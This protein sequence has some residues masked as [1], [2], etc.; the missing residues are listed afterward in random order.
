MKHALSAL[1]LIAS[2]WAAAPVP[3]QA[4]VFFPAPIPPVALPYNDFFVYSLP[5]L[6]YFLG[7]VWHIPSTPGHIQDGIVIATGANGAPVNTNFAGMDNPHQTPSGSGAS[8]YATTQGVSGCS[9]AEPGEV[10][11]AFAGDSNDSWDIQLSA[12]TSYLNGDD[13]VV[14]F[15]H[16]EENSGGASEQELLIWAHVIVEDVDG[17]GGTLD[18]WLSNGNENGEPYGTSDWVTATGQACMAPDGSAVD[19]TCT[20]PDASDPNIRFNHNLGADEAAFAVIFA[21]AGNNPYDWLTNGFD[22]MH[23]DWYM[24]G[25]SNGYEQAFILNGF[26]ICAPDDPRCI[27]TIAEPKPVFLLAL[28]LLAF[29]VASRFG[30]S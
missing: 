17:G 3:A 13:L 25:L 26:R 30:R 12:L 5:I 9:A 22:V 19:P 14:F 28:G 2:L 21:G 29:G 27:P 16:N 15:N 4:T 18:F 24:D 7:T 11:G 10:G 23:I 8:C 1:G 6:Q 20:N